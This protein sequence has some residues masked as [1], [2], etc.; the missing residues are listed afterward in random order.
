MDLGLE[1]KVALVTGASDGIGRAIAE[2]MTAAG[3]T[4]VINARNEERLLAAAAA[5]RSAGG[6]VRAV[7]GD[8]SSAAEVERLV[9]AVRQEEGDPDVL[10]VN[11]GGPPKGQATSLSDEEWGRAYELT[12]MSAV[13]LARAVLPA[14]RRAGWGRIVNVT[15][16]SVREPLDMLTLSNVMRSGLTAY[17]KTLATEV[18]A[19]GVTVNNVAPGYT[20]TERLNELFEDDAAKARLVAA[21]PAGRLAEPGEIAAAAAFLASRQAAYI[22]GQTLLVDGGFVKSPF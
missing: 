19:E 6:H 3:A 5:L 8:V 18:A 21:I 16:L 2:A 1:E 13:R 7:A 12:L 4:V 22:T 20:A 17:A 10:V 11:A 14:M 15:S 9:A